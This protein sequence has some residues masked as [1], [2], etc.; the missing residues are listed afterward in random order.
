MNLVGILLCAGKGR[1]FDPTGISNKL[2][3]T[4]DTGDAVVVASASYL[5]AELSH[6][7]A[8]VSPGGDHVATE[9]RDLGCEVVV[10]PEAVMGMAASLVAGI[11]HSRE[12]DGWIIALGDMPFVHSS[13]IAA[14]AGALE[15]G[16]TIAVPT[17]VGLRGNPVGF[18]SAH[19]SALLALQGDHG[20]RSILAHNVVQEVEVGDAGILRDIDTPADLDHSASSYP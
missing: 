7:V 4:L 17:Y 2:L 20:A 18:S 5:L 19:L 12:A 9:L 6:V 3:Q 11:H 10:C 14:L 13:T 15:G 8:V 16:A 1:R